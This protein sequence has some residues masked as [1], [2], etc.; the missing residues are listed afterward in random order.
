MCM[1][2]AAL[3]AIKYIQNDEDKAYCA[4]PFNS[5]INKDVEKI[6][7]KVYFPSIGCGIPYIYL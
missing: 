2:R 1:L 3:I 6:C 7:K 4:K 5:S